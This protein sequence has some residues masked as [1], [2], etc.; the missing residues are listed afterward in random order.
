MITHLE[1]VLSE[2]ACAVTIRWTPA[3]RGVEGNEIA[4]SCAKWA[5][6]A[7]TNPVDKEYLK[8]ASLPHLSRKTT[9]AR[10]QSTRE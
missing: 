4:D 10:S 7:Y 3:Y 8:E 1:R 5:A 9:E 6:E 2:R